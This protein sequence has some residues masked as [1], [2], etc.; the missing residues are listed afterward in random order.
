MITAAV[1]TDAVG[2]TI[3][4]AAT[5]ATA[6]PMSSPLIQ[7]RVMPPMIRAAVQRHA[8][9]PWLA[10]DG[11]A[12]TSPTGAGT[13]RRIARYSPTCDSWAEPVTR[14]STRSA[15][16]TAWSPMRS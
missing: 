3:A 1:S 4:V 13:H 8:T 14:N 11:L 10:G 5:A 7:V 16:E 9:A 6:R 2:A 15:T 12:N